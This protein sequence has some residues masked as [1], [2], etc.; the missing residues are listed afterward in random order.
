MNPAFNNLQN[1]FTLKMNCFSGYLTTKWEGHENFFVSLWN[2]ANNNFVLSKACAVLFSLLRAD[3]DNQEIGFIA[4]AAV[5]PKHA[6][7]FCPQQNTSEKVAS[8]PVR[9]VTVGPNTP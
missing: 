3:H 4:M 6:D 2:I 7:L 1:S 5:T 9:S 8:L